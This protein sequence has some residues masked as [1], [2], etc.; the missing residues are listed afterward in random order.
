MGIAMTTRTSMNIYWNPSSQNF[1]FFFK[2]L[3]SCLSLDKNNTY[4]KKK[5]RFYP[6]F[7]FFEIA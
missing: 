1:S 6:R 4:W 2:V 3:F 7:E 5:Y